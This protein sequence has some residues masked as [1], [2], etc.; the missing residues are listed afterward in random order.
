MPSLAI[1]SIELKK[2][3]LLCSVLKVTLF[4]RSF[5]YFTNLQ[6]MVVLGA[7]INIYEIFWGGGTDFF[8]LF[9]IFITSNMFWKKINTVALTKSLPKNL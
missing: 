9:D 4:Q 6:K 1:R 2:K 8:N 3:L 5:F 7:C